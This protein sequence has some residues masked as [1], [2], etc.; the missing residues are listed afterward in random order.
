M[1]PAG[2]RRLYEF[3]AFRLDPRRRVLER[4]GRPVPL[5]SKAFDV[6]TALVE[7]RDAALSKD[8]LMALVWSDTV[9]EENNLSVAISALR[10]A[11]GERPS[12]HQF[13][14]TLPGHGYRFAAPVNERAD[15][16]APPRDSPPGN[17]PAALSSFV[18]REQELADVARILAAGR[19]V[20]LTGSG[21]CGKTRLAIEAA[22]RLP[23][24]ARDGIWLV[25][26]AALSDPALVPQ[27]VASALGV[28]EAT[29]EPPLDTMLRFLDGRA[30]LVVLDNC[31]HVVDACA[32]LVEAL[33]SRAPAL[34]VLA[35]SREP[36]R[37]AGE[38][39]WRVPSLAV[40]PADATDVASVSACDSAR[41]FLERAQA[42][43]S[44]LT[45]NPANARDVARICRTLDGIPL[46]LE[47]AAARAGVLSI[48]Q[49]A[50]RLDDQFRLLTSGA[51]TARPRQRTL[52][53]SI[54]WSHALLTGEQ[55]TCLRR[56]SVFY[57]G[58][59]LEAA[60]QVVAGADA[61][62]DALQLLSDLVEKSLVIAEHDGG[63]VRYRILETVRQYARER[64]SDSGEEE[65]A[66]ARHLRFFLAL[67]E[68]AEA[69]LLGPRSPAWLA[70]LNVEHDNLRSALDWTLGRDPE[71]SLR[72]VG[73]LFRFWVMRGHLKE[74]TE[75]TQAALARAGDAVPP[76]VRAKALHAA[77]S[78]AF[79]RG[80][81]ARMLEWSRAS[82]QI[83]REH[84]EAYLVAYGLLLIAI[85]QLYGE[86]DRPG[87][88]AMLE[89]SLA[90]ARGQGDAFLTTLA[91]I[92]LG[93]AGI[94]ERRLDRAE[95]WLSEGLAV[96]RS[97]GNPWA[98]A[99]ALVN[100]G[101]LALAKGELEN[102]HALCTQSL[103]LR[104]QAGDRWGMLQSLEAL[105]QVWAA[106]GDA[107]RTACLM[108]ATAAIGGAIG[109][110]VPA[111][112]RESHARLQEHV[113]ALLGEA[114]FGEAWSRGHA[115]T[116]E[117]TVAL[118]CE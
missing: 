50:A 59:S 104:A 5:T 32:R 1:P 39:A 79:F 7:R 21:G 9:V 96:A 55:Q 38:T 43:S 95:P 100:A 62:P 52:R 90:L 22:R 69:E 12:E 13:I 14:V 66:R 115:L 75:R 113:K 29:G 56:L 102:A 76:L 28:R 117:R 93:Y 57:G 6:L 81:L 111:T 42:V 98:L 71:P 54:E 49:I 30:A 84:G 23:Q 89:E 18:G 83:A 4:D 65:S 35:T 108:G 53:A 20:T 64:L 112:V 107:Q 3:G 99:A 80:E 110:P 37:I 17:L 61:A 87:A 11:L 16:A 31:E 36:L 103:R 70:T 51:R 24:L 85:G 78:I 2:E 44:G 60:E 33:L 41:L 88:E 27:V 82:L 26:L 101:L 15:P 10:K 74:G 48:Q 105:V 92:N 73:A 97:L 91:L 58:F 46:A 77:A 72:L 68:R 45:L 106:R 25:E 118:A 8:E 40:P 109:A 67:A 94:L 47:L 63:G 114:E 116:L 86:G 19:L 34:R